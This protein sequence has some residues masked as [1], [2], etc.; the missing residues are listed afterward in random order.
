MSQGTKGSKFPKVAH[1]LPD[2]SMQSTA[3][4]TGFAPAMQRQNAR[5]SQRGVYGNYL[6]IRHRPRTDLL[7]QRPCE[8]EGFLDVGSDLRG[9]LLGSAARD[10]RSLSALLFRVRSGALWVQSARSMI[11]GLGQQTA[12]PVFVS[13]TYRLGIA[14]R[15]GLTRRRGFSS[16]GSQTFRAPYAQLPGWER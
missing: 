14:R 12:S 8:P 9:D 2:R 6:S 16:T 7:R 15:V 1:G 3:I 4:V 5:A 11:N 13:G 10:R